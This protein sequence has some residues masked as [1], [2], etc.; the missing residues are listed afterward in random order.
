MRRALNPIYR[1]DPK[2]ERTLRLLRRFHLIGRLPGSPPSFLAY[3]GSAN[4]DR[5]LHLRQFLE[6]SSNFKI[7][8]ISDN[9]FS[10]GA[11]LSK[12]YEKVYKLIESITANTYQWPIS[13]VVP[14]LSQK[15]T[16]GVNE[17]TETTAYAAQ[18]AQLNQM[19]KNMMTSPSMPSIE[20]VKAVTDTSEVACV[21]YGGAHL[22]EDC[23]SN[24]V[25]FNYVGN[26][27]YN[28][29]YSYGWPNHPNF[30]WSNNQNQPK[31][32]ASQTPQVPLGFSTPNYVMANQ[33]NK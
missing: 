14:S 12:S 31:P 4:D 7:L 22:F 21:Y 3:S 28:N 6:V 19:M 2:P 27:K 10:G 16:P 8:G 33:G 24:P 1:G 20:P 23:S 17:I 15:K 13:R 9:A 11:L 29:T 25:S 18:I 32:Q 30:S 26:N 5:H